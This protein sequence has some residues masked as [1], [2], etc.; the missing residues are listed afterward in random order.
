MRCSRS[1]YGRPRLD[2]VIVYDLEKL[3][4]AQK[5]NANAELYGI[6]QYKFGQLQLLFGIKQH[7]CRH[8]LAYVEWFDLAG[9]QDPDTQMFVAK[10]SNKFNVISVDAIIRNAHLIPFFEA[11]N[12]G[13]I[14]QCQ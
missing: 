3:E 5:N 8:H 11:T 9:H 4:K 6:S 13:R 7:G 14:A 10:R 1:F 2:W 12:S